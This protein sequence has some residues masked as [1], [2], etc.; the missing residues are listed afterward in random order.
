MIYSQQINKMKKCY[1]IKQRKNL[2]QTKHF[3]LSGSFLFNLFFPKEEKDDVEELTMTIKRSILLI[4]VRHNH[5][6]IIIK[7]LTMLHY[8]IKCKLLVLI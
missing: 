8:Y 4:Q 2:P 5:S 3:I 6:Y 1:S 7:V